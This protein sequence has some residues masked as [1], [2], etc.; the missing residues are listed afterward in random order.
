MDGM[1]KLK[2][3]E[4]LVISLGVSDGAQQLHILSLSIIVHHTEKVNLF[5]HVKHLLKYTLFVIIG[6]K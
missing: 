1:F 3:N 6:Y 4:F 5:N 2:E